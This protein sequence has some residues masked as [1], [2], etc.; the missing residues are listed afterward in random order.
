MAHLRRLYI[1]RVFAFLKLDRRAVIRRLKYL[2]KHILKPRNTCI[3]V[4]ALT[5]YFNKIVPG[6]AARF[7][8]LARLVAVKAVCFH[9]IAV[10]IK[11]IRSSRNSCG[12]ILAV[13]F[14]KRVHYVAVV[15]CY[16]EI[17]IIV[18]GGQIIFLVHSEVL[19][20]AYI[21]YVYRVFGGNLR[22]H[23]LIPKLLAHSLK[24]FH[25]LAV[26]FFKFLYC[27]GVIAVLIAAVVPGHQKRNF[28]RLFGNFLCA[29]AVRRAAR[30]VFSAPRKYCRDH[31]DTKHRGNYRFNFFQCNHPFCESFSIITAAARQTLP[32]S[33]L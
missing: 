10:I 12:I 2:V 15:P 8:T 27:L 5:R 18:N 24:N 33:A 28:F 20:H 32:A 13:E 4:V 16:A 17:H 7:I 26:G 14:N 9:N 3:C 22:R 11:H 19:I 25:L 31:T 6:P 30:S 23:L 29:L 1:K 21:K